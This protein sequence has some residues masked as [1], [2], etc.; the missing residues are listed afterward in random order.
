MAHLAR[1]T[2][3]KRVAYIENI[4]LFYMNK[5]VYKTPLNTFS[6]VLIYNSFDFF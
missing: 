4:I 2:R 1:Q 5:L 6:V 3:K